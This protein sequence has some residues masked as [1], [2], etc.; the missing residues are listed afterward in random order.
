MLSPSR[1]SVIGAKPYA[2]KDGGFFHASS[3][4][5][6]TTRA[7]SALGGLMVSPRLRPTRGRSVVLRA[8]TLESIERGSTAGSPQG[9]P[10]GRAS[11]SPRR[12]DR[13][14]W[15]GKGTRH[16]LVPHRFRFRTR[17]SPRLKATA[18][19]PSGT[20]AYAAPPRSPAMK[21]SASA[22]GIANRRVETREPSERNVF[23]IV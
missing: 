6:S 11:C 8:P 2:C 10:S 14:A 4:T 7:L 18:T 3:I 17:C 5:H 22:G 21:A 15:R 16:H 13:L 9:V 19:D 23:R 12:T 1:R 20:G